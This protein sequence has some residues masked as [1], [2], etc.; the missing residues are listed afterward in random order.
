MDI[1]YVDNNAT[2]RPADEVI[3]EMLPVLHEAYGAPSSLH[4]QGALARQKM[5]EARERA[6]RFLGADPAEIIFTSGGTES[7]HLAVLGLL[8]AR[9]GKRHV[10]TSAVEHLSVRS[11]CD[12]LR[13]RGIEVTEVGVDGDGLLRLDD[14]ASSLRADTALVTLMAANN[15]TGVVWPMA[16]IGRI[17]RG[18]GIPFH[19]DASVAGAWLPLDARAAGVDS[20]SLSGHKL[21]GPKGVG[22]LYLRR[23]LRLSPLF[24]GGRQERGRRPG[25]ENVAGI[26]GMG[27]AL[28]LVVERRPRDVEAVSRMRDR[29][30]QGICGRVPE[31]V[32]NGSAAPRLPN[33]SHLSFAYIEGEAILL[34]LSKAGIC[35]SSGS[36]CTTG[37]VEPSYVLRAM[38]KPDS[39]AHGA[40]RFSFSRYNREEE[41]EVLLE[42]VPL[43]VEQ[44]REL[45]PFWQK[46]RMKARGEG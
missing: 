10:V 16:E 38:G 9:P 21:H 36:A 44:L 25:T 33:T 41:V 5:E 32:P 8:E 28:E 18:R 7:N 6:A 29:F 34:S 31:C 19:V 46:Q 20:L 26:A 15:E 17:V 11:L 2:T 14:L 42:K 23:G 4:L 24:H 22:L 40:V 35:A 37:L 27:K 30:E 3:E 13:Q 45:S 43:A 39:L 1:V 12:K